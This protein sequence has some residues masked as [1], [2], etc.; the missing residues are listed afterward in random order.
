MTFCTM[1]RTSIHSSSG[2]LATKS[3]PSDLFVTSV[4]W[5]LRW[6]GIC[7]QCRRPEFDP[8]V[9]KIPWRRKWKPIPVFLPGKS[10]GQRSLIGY[11][12]QDHK[13]LDM[14]KRLHFHF[15]CI[16]I[17]DLILVIDE[18]PSGFVYFLQF[19]PEFCNKE[20]II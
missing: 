19:K 18:W 6:Y 15:H 5:W 17:R 20:F 13:E 2:T 14:T 4:P 9:E 12:P 11:S 16:I 10:H 3:N 1:L 7:L 8:C